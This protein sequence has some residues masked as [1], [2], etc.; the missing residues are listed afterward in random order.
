MMR[1]GSAA[2]L[3]CLLSFA[4]AAADTPLTLAEALAYADAAHPDL[5]QAE[6]DLAASLAEREQAA[7][8]QDFYLYLDGALSTGEQSGGDWRA[9]N[10]GRLV[11]LK[12]LLDFG[13]TEQA[14]AAADQEILARRAALLEVKSARRVDLMARYF[15]VLLADMQYAADNEFM[16]VA[17]VDW[18]NAKVR[19]E[20][21]QIGLPQL[22]DLEA[23]YQDVRER[24]NASMQRMRSARQ[25]LANAMNRPG[26]LPSELEEPGLPEND[27]ALAGYENLLSRM[28]EHNPRVRALHA[29]LSAVDARIAMVRADSNPTL[30]AEVYGAG[31][32][33]VSNTRDNL[34]AGLVFLVPLYQ[35]GR[36]DARI[37]RELGQK[38]RL[39]AQLEKLKLD[40][41]E[42]LLDT[43]Q[44]I[45][46]LRDSAR[47]A[48]DK[49]L[50]YR[51][52]VLERSRAEYELELKT[53][54]GTS[55]AETQAAKLRRKRVD[56]RL[57]LA[58]ARLDALLG[59]ELPP[60]G[61]KK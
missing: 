6:G 20:T 16:A 27:Q 52:W 1:C 47:A 35:G 29:Q 46:W 37:A 25:K 53:S 59:S 41:S 50:E 51:D 36:V 31:Y 5:T 39:A 58:L 56:Y 13:R 17:Y 23:R 32:S 45:D 57:A 11:A 3:A 38:D 7:S 2:L 24:R 33:R 42:A 8:R 14:I 26:K 19:R 22:L 12:P 55:M 4:A 44:E 60:A 43:L 28:T 10:I 21:G 15:D 40:L 49:Q 48:A 18:D 9:N 61:Q 54:L 30:D 34:S